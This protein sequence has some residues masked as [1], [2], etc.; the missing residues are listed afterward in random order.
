[1]HVSPEHTCHQ[2]GSLSPWAHLS[3]RD[4]PVTPGLTCHPGLDPGSIFWT[5]ATGDG[6]TWIPDQVRDDNTDDV[7]DDKTNGVRDDKAHGVQDDKTHGVEDDK[8]NGVR[9]DT[10]DDNGLGSIIQA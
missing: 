1:M 5:F 4:I 9:G 10:T 7:R 2:G 3:P 6:G 8:T